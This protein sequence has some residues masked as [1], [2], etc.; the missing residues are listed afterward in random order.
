MSCHQDRRGGGSISSAPL[1]LDEP[2]GHLAS[3]RAL[4]RRLPINAGRPRSPPGSRGDDGATQ[5]RPDPIRGRGLGHIA[6]VAV[7]PA[8]AHARRNSRVAA[9]V[10]DDATKLKSLAR[11]YRV[12][13]VCSYDDYDSCLERVD[14]VYIALPNSLHAEIF[15]SRRRSRRAR[16]LREAD[17]GDGGRM[18]ADDRRLPR[19]QRQADDRVS[20]AFRRDQPE[21][22]R[23]GPPRPNRRRRSSSI[24]RSP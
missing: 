5:A 7:L 16:A 18:S 9:L 4:Q 8:F 12:A 21:G 22:R 19:K 17:G 1:S 10:S 15:D 3:A 11:R 23:S 6:Q 2:T 20:A 24:R 13:D 14:A